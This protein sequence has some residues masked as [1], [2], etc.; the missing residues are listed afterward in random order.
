[1]YLSVPQHVPTLHNYGNLL[2]KVRHDY[3]MAEARYKEA[4]KG[5]P[6]HVPKLCNY[7]NPLQNYRSNTNQAEAMYLKALE[8]NPALGQQTR[9]LFAITVSCRRA[10]KVTCPLRGLVP[11]GP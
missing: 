2:I 5:D 11:Q 9:L 6:Y 10:L 8:S 4:L 7:G 1:M 3:T